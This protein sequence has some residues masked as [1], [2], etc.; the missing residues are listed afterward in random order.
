M[1]LV[2]SLEKIENKLDKE[3]GSNKLGIHNTLREKGRSRS[4]SR[5]HYHSQGNSNRRAHNKSSPSHVRKHKRSGVDELRGEMNKIKPPTFDGEQ[6]KDEY[7]EAW[8]LGKRK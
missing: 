6:K 5:H 1:K 3:S 8:L 2:Q 7:D 4:G